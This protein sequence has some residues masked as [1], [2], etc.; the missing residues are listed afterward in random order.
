MKLAAE[1]E[2]QKWLIDIDGNFKAIWDVANTPL[3]GYIM[4]FLP[5]KISFVQEPI[6]IW[7]IFDMFVDLFFLCDIIVTFLTPFYT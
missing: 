4:M 5:F 1:N 2:G 6:L 3:I 7:E